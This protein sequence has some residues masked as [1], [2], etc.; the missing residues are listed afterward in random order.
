MIFPWE[1][2]VV[3]LFRPGNFLAFNLYSPLYF[4]SVNKDAYVNLCFA[5]VEKD[6]HLCVLQVFRGMLTSGVLR[7]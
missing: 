2:F 5:C 1:C 4:A 6:A 3:L 7:C